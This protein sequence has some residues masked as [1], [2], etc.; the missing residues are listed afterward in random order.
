[1]DGM[2]AP[3]DSMLAGEAKG[4]DLGSMMGGDPFTMS[5]LIAEKPAPTLHLSN[6]GTP[7]GFALEIHP[8]AGGGGAC[9]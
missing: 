7:T 6:H 8:A 3:G 9:P 2:H 4:D 1:M 5:G